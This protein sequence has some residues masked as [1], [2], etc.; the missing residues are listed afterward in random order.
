MKPLHRTLCWSLVALAALVVGATVYHRALLSTDPRSD[1]L[2]LRAAGRAALDATDI[3]AVDYP[4]A[5]P[6]YY[7]PTMAVCL[8]PFA[9]MP[10]P[11]AV[12]AW[13]LLSLAALAWAA[14]RLA[15]L[16]GELLPPPPREP[17]SKEAVSEP[18]YLSR[19][20]LRL[21][22]AA[23]VAVAL[24]VN[25]GPIIDGLHRGQVSA[26]LFALMVE[27]LWQ[28]R[29]DRSA[30]CGLCIA[31]AACLKLYP[32]LLLLPLLVRRDARGLLGFAVGVALFA[33]LLPLIGFGPTVALERTRDFTQRILLPFFSDSA[34]G[35]KPEFARF[36]QFGFANQSLYAVLVRW[37]SDSALPDHRKF[38]LTLA[39]WSPDAVRRLAAA[40]SLALVLVMA[41]LMYRRAPRTTLRD[42]FL[43]CLPPVAANFISHVAW[44]NYYTVTSLLYAVCLAVIVARRGTSTATLLRWSLATAVL[45]NWLHFASNFCRQMGLLLAGTMLLW[46]AA[47]WAA[48]RETAVGVPGA[49]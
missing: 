34:F 31:L 32:A 40:V 36:S 11:P 39:D 19:P 17:Q 25:F 44:H 20:P 30:Y 14:R 49:R 4:R 8:I 9:A 16:C 3:Y 1:F 47:A 45:C 37:L 15:A 48:H 18:L 42:A 46:C 23:V 2:M 6:Y 24:A 43:W 26:L 22:P 38:A 21:S 41:A 27:A 13:Y 33:G 10:A 7:P 29:R 12:I 35:E 28:Y 5:G